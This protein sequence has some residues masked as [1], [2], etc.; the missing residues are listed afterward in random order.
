ML[1]LVLFGLLALGFYASVTTAVQV[2]ANQQRTNKA[3]LA[4]ESGV[5]F[6]RYHLAHVTVPSNSTTV[7]ADL[8]ADLKEALEG[9]TNLG[10]NTVS[11][12]NN[13]IYIPAQTNSYIAIDSEE[14]IGFAATIK[15]WDGGIVC[16]VMGR[17]GAS[18]SVNT[19]SVSLEFKRQQI[20]SNAFDYAV[21]SKG[22]VKMIKGSLTGV[23]GVSGNEIATVMS[24]KED[25]TTIT[26][27]GGSIGGELNYVEPAD[28]SVTG[29]SVAGSTNISDINNNHVHAVAEPDFPTFDT[30]VFEQ[31]VTSTYTGGSVLSN[32][33]IPANTNPSFLGGATIQGIVYIE[34]PNVVEFRGNVQLNGFIVFEQANDSTQN[35]IDMRGNFTWGP[36]PSD[37]I[38]DPLRSTTGI[39][40]LA[41]TTHITMSGSSDST[42]RG[43]FIVGKFSNQ[44]SADMT[45]DQGTL[46]TLDEGESAIFNGKKV[47]FKATGK[48]N[49]PSTGTIYSAYF[50]PIQG[51]FQELN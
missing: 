25:G 10:S 3:R 27:E 5:Q 18:S 14:N 39:A 23:D 40:I 34:S 7:L 4:A 15:E 6:M 30:T 29:G 44:G 33:R 1:F 28:V 49:Q 51:S 22:S 48:L 37:P 46:M 45:I 2:T 32:V 36:L 19:K 8:Y 47:K 17:S 21:A 42:V 38:Y 9:T 20:P 13:V 31:Y 16:T 24:A 43:N 41:P 35:I 12:A 26:V 50:D 11:I